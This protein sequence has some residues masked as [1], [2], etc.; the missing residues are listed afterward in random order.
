M[1]LVE[2]V[3]A[4][5]NTLPI[6]MPFSPRLVAILVRTGSVTLWRRFE[7]DLRPALTTRLRRELTDL[8]A[9]S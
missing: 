3:G 5:S 6:L 9:F 1:S 4:S 2:A 8:I 7:L